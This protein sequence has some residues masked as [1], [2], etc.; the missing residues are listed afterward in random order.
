MN[1]PI[2]SFCFSIGTMSIVRTPPSSTAQPI[3]DCVFN[4]GLI[5]RKIGDMNER[6]GREHDDQYTGAW[7]TRN[8]LDNTPTA[9]VLRLGRRYFVIRH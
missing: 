6:F 7:R 4:V 9:F 2:S 8:G 1:A 5:C 3:S